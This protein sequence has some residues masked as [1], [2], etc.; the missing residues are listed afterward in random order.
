MIL[1]DYVVVVGVGDFGS[2]EGTSH[3][4]FVGA[5]VVDEDFAVDLGGVKGGAALPEEFGLFGFALRRGWS[6]SWPTQAALGFGA[7]FLPEL[8]QLAASCRNGAVGD[9]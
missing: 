7:D 4:G 8:H 6:I 1:C 5:E 9:L 3:E 2:V